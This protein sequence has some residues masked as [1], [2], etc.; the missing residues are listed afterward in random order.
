MSTL[1]TLALPAMVAAIGIAA[2][3]GAWHAVVEHHV[4]HKLAHKANP[5]VIVPLTRHDARWHGASHRKRMAVNVAM[6]GGAFLLAG[7]WQ[8]DRTATAVTVIVAL[9]AWGA[10]ATAHSISGWLGSRARRPDPDLGED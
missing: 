6:I 2:L 8:L 9:A 7:G 3:A 5:A 4:L 1:N 10:W